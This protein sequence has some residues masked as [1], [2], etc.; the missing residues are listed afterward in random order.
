MTCA[1]EIDES[2]SALSLR[3]DRVRRDGGNAPGTLYCTDVEGTELRVAVRES[4]AGD[5]SWQAG[6][7]YRLDGVVRSTSPGAELL[8]PS[9]DGSAD[10]VDAPESRTHPPL[11]DLDD[12]WLV[13][14]GASDERVAVTVQLRPVD[15]AATS[16]VR[17]AAPESFQIGAVCLSHCEE[18]DATVYHREEPD[19]RD[20]HLLLQHV[21]EDLSEAAGAT[22][23]TRGTDRSPL[24][25][26][27]AR[28]DAAAGDGVV[29]PGAGAVLD[30]CFHADAGRVAAR[31]AAETLT[32]AARELGV[33]TDPVRL[34]DYDIGDDPADWREGWNTDDRPISGPS[35]P[36]MTDRDYAALV[37]RYLG[38]DDSV[39]AAALG[40]CLKAYASAD[41]SLLGDLATDDATGR[42]AC[43]RPAGRLPSP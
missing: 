20:E 2:R 24:G 29:D 23:V 33:E 3:V 35:D 32:A 12:P 27:R 21:V 26:L 42:L 25:A 28:L 18:P 31:A 11:A 6:R 40:N 36:R 37:E 10:R 7:W 30:G 38:A 5:L 19:V 34:D 15:G 16:P 4:P 9:G 13:Q 41:L 17:A 8:F 22:L 1:R 43:S 14:L 39:A